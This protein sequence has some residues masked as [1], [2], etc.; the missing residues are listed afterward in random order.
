MVLYMAMRIR[1]W[2]LARNATQQAK[3]RVSAMETYETAMTRRMKTLNK[4]HQGDST[5]VSTPRTPRGAPTS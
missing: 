5:P 3:D 4:L 1:Q 2:K